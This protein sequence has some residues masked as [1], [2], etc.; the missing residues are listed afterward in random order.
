MRLIPEIYTDRVSECRQFYCDYLGFSVEREMDGFVVLQH[1]TDAECRIMFCVPGSPFVDR[2]FHPAFDGEG[3]IFQIDTDNV[4][5]DYAR[6]RS[7]PVTIALDLVEE[8][9]NGRHFTITDPNGLLID[10]VQ[11]EQWPR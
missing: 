1:A 8:E 10:I 6:L 3:L 7:L 11:A 5:A 4:D 2:I 9:V